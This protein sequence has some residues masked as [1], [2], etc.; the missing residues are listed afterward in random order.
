MIDELELPIQYPTLPDHVDGI[1]GLD[2]LRLQC[3]DCGAIHEQCHKNANACQLTAG[4]LFHHCDAPDGIRRC[5]EC[6]AV[7]KAA[8]PNASC[9]R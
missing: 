9:K 6:L 1:I 4:Y 3:R 5:P 8:C 2:P 7:A